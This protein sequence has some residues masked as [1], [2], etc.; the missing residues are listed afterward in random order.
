LRWIGSPA[1]RRWADPV[2]GGGGQVF[3]S[4]L[5]TLVSG[6]REKTSDRV[7]YVKD[8]RRLETLERM[9]WLIVRVVSGDRPDVVRRVWPDATARSSAR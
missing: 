8:I 2:G 7:H 3:L 9:G 1:G 4:R 5:V 6:Q